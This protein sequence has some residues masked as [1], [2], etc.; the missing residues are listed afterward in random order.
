[1]GGTPDAGRPRRIWPWFLAAAAA[2][3]LGAAGAVAIREPSLGVRAQLEIEGMLEELARW[4]GERGGE[5][6]P[7][8]APPEGAPDPARRS[9][10]W[11]R[12]YRYERV[13]PRGPIRIWSVGGDGRDERGGGDDVASWTR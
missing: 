4:A 7:A 9:D 5:F 8:E 10:P 11:G 3:G 6:P 12:P 13:A 1:M 2:V